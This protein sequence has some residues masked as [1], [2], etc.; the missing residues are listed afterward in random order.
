[1][2]AD[3]DA[4]CGG[5][6]AR[7]A[8][9]ALALAFALAAAAAPA[10]AAG[11]SLAVAELEDATPASL[12]AGA[13][14]PAFRPVPGR[15]LSPHPERMRWYR[16]VPAEAWRDA[17]PP[18]L[19]AYAPYGNRITVV[20]SG[21][22]PESRT[23][24]DA[25]LDPRW[26]RH[27]LVFE[28]DPALSPATPVYV[29]VDDGKRFPARLAL[30]THAEFAR[31]EIAYARAMTAI[32]A[33]IAVMCFVIGAF[34]L[35]L[36]ERT[37]GYLFVALVL[38][39]AYL[40]FITGEAYALPGFAGLGASGVAAVWV[41]RALGSASLLV[42][43]RRFLEVDAHAPRLARALGVASAGFVVLALAGP[44][45]A[46]APRAWVP[47]VGNLLLFGSSA[48]ALVAGAIAWRHGVRAA[49]F[50][51]P[52]WLPILSLDMLREA[53][54]LGWAEVYPGNEYAQ[55]GAVA[56]AAVL[57][58]A[59][60]ADRLLA[61]RR[62][63]DLARHE[64]ERDALTGT[65]N[66]RAIVARIEAACAQPGAELALLFIDLDHFKRINDRA[67]HATGDACLNAV[68]SIVDEELR[69]ADAL[70]RFGG[71]EFVVML[72]G[73]NLAQA[74]ATAERIRANVAARC[75]VVDGHEVGLTASIGV[76]DG[77]G[78]SA[79]E[80]IAAGDR[81]MYEAKDGG[82]NLVRVAAA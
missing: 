64:A 67:G 78:R 14:E 50:F 58:S 44:I 52:A 36:R 38:T 22:A 4:G 81:A 20:A 15:A 72:D 43:V 70:G 23:I 27:A 57:F 26:S 82:R 80:L 6:R 73:A 29:G 9:A 46:L 41:V 37:L 8:Q 34:A 53:Q 25:G 40:G 45:D 76:A 12:L 35:T 54:L 48:A 10:H 39:L 16:V 42:F 49:R 74:E 2:Q 59:G 75:R 51:L 79:A 31:G 19:V 5:W 11:F 24:R 66:R 18:L 63:R 60:M 55:P 56:L 62:E 71:E 69:Q 68:V 77:A 30:E 21:R 7:V 32:L 47:V 28:L 33:A 13:H 17:E 61:V 65:L 1:M 3:R